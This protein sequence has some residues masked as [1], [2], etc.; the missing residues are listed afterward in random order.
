MIFWNI[1]LIIGSFDCKIEKNDNI[2]NF[3]KS[4]TNEK[5]YK[6]ILTTECFLL[7]E[8]FSE[9]HGRISFW[10]TLF[11]INNIKLDKKNHIACIDFYKEENK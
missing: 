7:I 5:E 11:A 10:S 8:K 4:L 2:N 6:I 9:K 1:L 3:I